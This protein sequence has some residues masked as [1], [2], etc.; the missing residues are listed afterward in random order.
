MEKDAEKFDEFLFDKRII[1]RNIEKKLI[2]ESDYKSYLSRLK[3]ESS[4]CEKVDIE[5]LYQT[6]S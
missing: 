1:K 6:I 4:D 2:S 5:E 3:D